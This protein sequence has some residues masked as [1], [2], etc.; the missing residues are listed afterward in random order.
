MDLLTS[1]SPISD[2]TDRWGNTLAVIGRLKPGSS[3]E[4]ARAEFGLLV[5]QLRQAHPERGTR[6][7]ARLTALQQQVSGQFRRALV[8]LLCAV[9]VVLVI[10]CANLSNLLL[11]RAASRR[12]EVAV[13]VALGATRGRL[14]RQL[15]TESTL[16]ACGGA[17]LGLALAWAA[18]RALA[19]LHGMNIPLLQAVH[20]DGTALAFTVAVT[21]ATGLAFGIA[22]ALQISGGD[23]HEGLKENSRGSSDGRRGAWIR[24]AL[25]VSEIALACM[26]LVGAGLLIRSFLHV[27]DVDLGFQPA[28]A[29]VWTI[30]TGDRYRT[31]TQQA[32]FYRRLEQAVLAVPGVEAAGVTDCLPLGRNRTWGVRAVGET[33]GPGQAPLAFPRIVDAGYLH[34]MRIPQRA[35]R[36]FSNRDTASSERVVVVNENLA[37]RLWPG[38]DPLGKQALIT[39]NKPWR[40]VGVVGNVRHSSLE[41]EGGSEFYLPVPQIGSSSVELVVR[42]KLA[43]GSAGSG[44]ARRLAQRGFLAAYGGVPHL[45]RDRGPRR[46]AAAVRGHAA[47]RVRHAGAGVG[48]AG[49]L[50]CG[51][52]LRE[53]ALAG[54]RHSHGAGRVGL[55]SAVGVSCG[56]PWRWRCAAARF[57]DGGLHRRGAFAG[58]APVR[59]H[60]LASARRTTAGSFRDDGQVRACGRVWLTPAL[61]PLLQC[62]FADAIGSRE[63]SLRHFH[64]L[65][66]GL[67]VDRLRPNLLQFD[68][69][70]LVRQDQLHS[71]DQVRSKGCLLRSR[72]LWHS[73]ALLSDEPRFAAILSFR[74]RSDPF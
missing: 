62:A 66:N 61:L 59:R 16:L 41:E 24:G 64:P 2:E 31:D 33:Y 20:V 43:P 19:A 72:F 45:G 56:K 71:L 1:R 44:R 38:R 5:P 40:V 26:L 68:F 39:D 54:D 9:G 74:P 21:I 49:N 36:D 12:K 30:E 47:G 60:S 22:P 28:R 25:V 69:A 17:T 14:I 42:A 10:A 11:A 32:D 70:A 73:I 57:G 3:V 18:T 13:R 48:V 8:V 58:I 34:A 65:A 51:V 67:H 63:F 4:Q 7:D 15:L 53:S 29:A 27:M 52:V 50:R 6:W 23:V 35:G 55:P 37:R 46:F